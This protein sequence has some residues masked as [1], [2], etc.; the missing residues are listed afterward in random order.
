MFTTIN[1]GFIANLILKTKVK[2]FAVL[3][4]LGLF[5]I[6]I[7]A[8]FWAIFGRINWEFQITLLFIN[9]IAFIKYNNPI[10]T[11]YQELF[12][13]LKQLPGSFKV[14]L[15][16]ITLLIVAQCAAAPYGIDNETYYIQT[17]KWLNEYGFVKG[18]GNL[19][20]YLSQTSAWHIAQ[21]AFSFS[22]LY[23]N[24]NDLSGYCLLLGNLFALTK[25][26]GY[27]TN[28]VRQ[29]L[30]VGLL[31]LANLFLFQFISA[32]SP[33][34]AVYIF[35]FIAFFYFIKKYNGIDVP[36]FVIISLLAIFCVFIKSTAVI[37]IAMPLIL[38]MVNFKQ[39]WP[40]TLRLTL[41]S[42][43]VLLL[44]SIKNTIISGHP[45]Y[46]VMLPGLAFTN[47]ALS[48]EIANMHY[49]QAKAYSFFVTPGHYQTMSAWQLF[50]KWL[51][52]PKL[53]GVFNKIAIALVV[54]SP[55][56]IYRFYN[57]KAVW[58]LYFI[59]CLQ[60]IFL[61]YTSPQYRF[62]LNFLMLFGLLILSLLTAGKK[63]VIMGLLYTSVVV[64]GFV[65]FVPLNLNKFSGKKFEL[66]TSTFSFKNILY[67]HNNTRFPGS[68]NLITKG[69]LKYYSLKDN[70]YFWV[71]GNGSLPCASEKQL[72]FFENAYGIIPQLRGKT[73]KEGFYARKLPKK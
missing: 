28:G 58:I 65:L 6:S 48:Q 66:A 57:K 47:Y 49:E 40:K 61:F 67:P 38:L 11:I 15:G 56:I 46:P 25:L 3:S 71:T 73:I 8:C 35:S 13:T 41:L 34:V 4:V 23:K 55:L 68:F 22:F 64:T 14:L 17:I 44:F 29:N 59:M 31:P 60:I 37:I 36:S 19:H 39:L 42:F 9:T 26:N 5:L 32:P 54:A 18:L 12:S 24:F 72:Q 51:M 2:N 45:L 16:S 53:Y 63:T 50:I 1:F 7:T 33:D 52:L 27:F 20:P 10:L 62:Y 70:S 43:T 21:S 69:N 30:I